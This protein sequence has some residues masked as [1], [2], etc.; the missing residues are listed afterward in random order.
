MQALISVV[1]PVYN[2]EPYL[3]RCLNSV[4]N[5]TYKNLEIICVNDG[6]TDNCREILGRYAMRDDRIQVINQ[7]NQ[8]LSA[9]RNSGINQATG[10][11]LFYLDSDDWVHPQA[12]EFLLRAAEESRSDV[13]LGGKKDITDYDAF[14]QDPDY[15]YA[16]DGKTISAADYVDDSGCMRDVVWGTLYRSA[17]VDGC[18]FPEGKT[19]AEDAYYNTLIISREK[20][21]RVAFVDFPLYY[22]YVTRA[23]S[24]M[25]GANANVQLANI[26]WWIKNIELFEYKNYA[27]SHIF[28]YIF[29]YWYEGRFCQNPSVARKNYYIC[30]KRVFPYFLKCKKISRKQRI[31]AVLMSVLPGLYRKIIAEKDPSYT[32]WEATAKEQLKSLVLKDWDEV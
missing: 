31:K 12:F 18:R 22:Y 7:R 21:I 3:E 10:E 1:I 15:V 6:S 11:Y 16:F 28:R 24:I 26:K 25:K 20:E 32:A 29:F 23:G 14:E 8:G 2:V 5:S 13:V 9:A 17:S 27:L 19:Y 30:L 4:L